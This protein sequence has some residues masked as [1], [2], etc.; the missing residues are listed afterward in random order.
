METNKLYIFSK[1]Y[2]CFPLAQGGSARTRKKELMPAFPQANGLCQQQVA[3]WH[4]IRCLSHCPAATR[5]REVSLKAKTSICQPGRCKSGEPHLVLTPRPQNRT[6]SARKP[7]FLPQWCNRS[8]LQC[9]T[10]LIRTRRLF[11]TRC[12]KHLARCEQEDVFAPKRL[13]NKGHVAKV[14]A[15]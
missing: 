15:R 3:D 5:A 8:A 4:A 2:L 9:H 10:W 6:V 1:R 11:H 7:V 13:D 12:H 14:G